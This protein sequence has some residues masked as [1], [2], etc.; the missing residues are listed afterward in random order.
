VLKRAKSIDP[1][2]ILDA[3]A[4]TNYNSMVGP[5]HWTGQPVKNVSKTP[6]VAGQCAYPAR[7]DLRVALVH[8]RFVRRHNVRIEVDEL[9]LG[10][11]SQQI[12]HRPAVR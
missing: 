1:K 10:I 9:T 5:V 12:N 11:K 6:F 3:I 2:A 8:A 4:A 7:A